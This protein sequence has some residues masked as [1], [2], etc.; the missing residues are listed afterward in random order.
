MTK[1]KRGHFERENDLNRITELY[2]KQWRQVDIAKE[3]GVS[4]Q[5]ISWDLKVVQKRWLEAELFN[6]NEIKT[7]ELDRIDTLEREYW[8][9]WERSKGRRFDHLPS[10]NPKPQKRRKGN[11]LD[12]VAEFLEDG[13]D[14]ASGPEKATATVVSVDNPFGDPRYLTGVQWC[15]N[16]RII[17]LGLDTPSKANAATTSVATESPMTERLRLDKIREL[18][19]RAEKRKETN[20]HGNG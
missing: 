12:E 3:I 13:G 1:G 4:Q 19:H 2:L 10:Q 14:K 9:A 11:V 6:M 17:L 5:Q 15:I 8:Q 18:M 7:R 16:R 20:G